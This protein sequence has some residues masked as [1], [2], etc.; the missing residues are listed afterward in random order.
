VLP[1]IEATWR[2]RPAAG[3]RRLRRFTVAPSRALAEF[4]PRRLIHAEAAWRA[5]VKNPWLRFVLVLVLVLLLDFAGISRTRTTTRTR[6]IA[7]LGISHTG[8]EGRA[9]TNRQLRDAQRRTSGPVWARDCFWALETPGAVGGSAMQISCCARNPRAARDWL[10]ST[11]QEPAHCW[12][13]VSV[14]AREPKSMP[15]LAEVPRSM[16]RDVQARL[17]MTSLCAAWVFRSTFRLLAFRR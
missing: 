11:A 12:K 10:R 4:Q 3:A 9:P 15:R 1:R 17:R 8:S 16:A 7:A 13:C 6:R 2:S 5:C 14:V